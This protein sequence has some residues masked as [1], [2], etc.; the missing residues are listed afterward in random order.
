[1]KKLLKIFAFAT[2]LLAVACGPEEEPVDPNVAITTTEVTDIQENSAKSGGNITHD[3]GATI[4]SRGVCYGTEATPT[5]DGKHT[6]DGSGSG[7]YV[8][9]LTDLTPGTTYY[10]RA[11]ATNVNGITYGNEVVFSVGAV[12]PV[13]TTK[14]VTDVT[15]TTAVVSGNVG[16]DGGSEITEYGVCY[17]TTENP[18]VE[19]TK[20]TATADEKG[21]Y[22]VT[23]E[24]LESGTTYYVRAYA[25]NG[26]GT[27]YGE[28]MTFTP[29]ADP[30]IAI[31]D[32]KL[33]AHLL[34][35]CDANSDGEIVK[36][37]ALTVTAL[38]VGEMGIASFAGLENFTNLVEFVA[39][40]ANPNTE[41]SNTATSID[42]SNN[43]ALKVFK[44]NFTP[45]LT[46]LNLEGCEALE[47]V[48]AFWNSLPTVN[49][50]GCTNLIHFHA[51][52]NGMTSIDLSDCVNLQY[53]NISEN[54]IESLDVSNNTK[55]VEFYANSGRYTSLD[56]SNHKEL[57][58]LDI[59]LGAIESLN[60][61]GCD[62]LEYIWAAQSNVKNWDLSNLTNLKEL[63]AHDL[64]QPVESVKYDNCGA[65]LLHWGNCD[66]T[67]GE[68]TFE[69]L[70]N[71]VEA[72]VWNGEVTKATYKNCPNLKIINLDI[73]PLLTELVIE[74]CPEITRLQICM[75]GLTKLDVTGLLKLEHIQVQNSVNMTELILGNNPACVSVFCHENTPLTKL[76]LSHCASVM[77]E[78]NA[79]TTAGTLSQIVLKEGQV[80]NNLIKPESATVTYVQ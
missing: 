71:L 70:P 27:A 24:G 34:T 1:M 69:N 54:P 30:I 26:V 63:W 44:V 11:Y 28:Q 32:A 64:K 29:D 39:I 5:I 49:L 61:Q 80:V 73:S 25:I 23:L 22:T 3:G 21:N 35:L 62:K 20:V 45:S 13:V 4:T 12:L 48:E 75:L 51:F 16:Y 67:F 8:S 2:A 52:V 58:K 18:T 53:S 6:K 74:N 37:E 10:V 41:N 79:N 42:F 46:S 72:V 14:S 78:V 66:F 17:A 7:E 57:V 47:V 59:A 68:W 38:N 36:S 31:T 43:K 19:N 76:D 9:L 77:N 40:N 33:K 55:L 65:T 60:V 50:T 56:I 15:T